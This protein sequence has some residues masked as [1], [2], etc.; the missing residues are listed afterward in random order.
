MLVQ[1]IKLNPTCTKEFTT[2]WAEDDKDLKAKIN[3]MSLVIAKAHDKVSG[4]MSESRSTHGPSSISSY[5]I[6]NR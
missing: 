4:E 1:H 6:S 5:M 2:S 3:N